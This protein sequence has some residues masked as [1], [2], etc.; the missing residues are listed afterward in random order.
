MRKKKSGFDD[1]L[2]NAR[3]IRPGIEFSIHKSNKRGNLAIRPN[4]G[5]IKQLKEYEERI[6]IEKSQWN[7]LNNITIEKFIY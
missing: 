1:T 7:E 5:F 2:Q 6:G 4:D 3:T